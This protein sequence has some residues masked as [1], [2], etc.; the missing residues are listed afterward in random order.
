MAPTS[1]DTLIHRFT[2]NFA[3]LLKGLSTFNLNQNKIRSVSDSD[4]RFR[5]PVLEPVLEILVQQ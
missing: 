2:D 1:G 5:L 4:S 3:A